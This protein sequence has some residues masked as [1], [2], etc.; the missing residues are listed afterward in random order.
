MDLKKHRTDDSSFKG[1]NL[2]KLSLVEEELGNAGVDREACK[3]CGLFE[4]AKTHF[5][6]PYI[7]KKWTRKLLV[8]RGGIPT[9]A[10][11]VLTRKLLKGAGYGDFDVVYV[12]AIRCSGSDRKSVTMVSIRACRP[13]LLRV[14][15]KLS[16]QVVIGL[17]ATAMRSLRNNGSI[18]VTTNRG[19][20][21]QI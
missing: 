16:P 4:G 17:G 11:A 6:I 21:I 19:K 12:D 3:V 13:F 20:E 14:I 8:V 5:S 7:L 2:K 9:E 15:N 18:N 1:V 10:T